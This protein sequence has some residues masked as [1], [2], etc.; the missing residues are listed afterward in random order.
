[1]LL[2]IFFIVCCCSPYIDDGVIPGIT[3]IGVNARIPS[4]GISS[5]GVPSIRISSARVTSLVRLRHVEYLHLIV[6][7]NPTGNF[8]SIFAVLRNFIFWSKRVNSRLWMHRVTACEKMKT[9]VD[10]RVL[11]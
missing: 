2:N 3:S 5:T 9:R 11:F 10:Q 1:V 4:T 6:H 8:S 7:C